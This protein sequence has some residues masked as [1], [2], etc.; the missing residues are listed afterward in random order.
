MSV[1][2]EVISTSL[3]PVCQS[4]EVVLRNEVLCKQGD[5]QG[6]YQLG[7]IVNGKQSWK[8]ATQAIWFYP[9]YE[10]WAIGSL[11]EIG[12]NLRGISSAAEENKDLF[13]VANDDWMYWDGDWK[14][15]N[16]GDIDIICKDNVQGV[17]VQSGPF[18]S[19]IVF[20]PL[21]VRGCYIHFIIQKG[22]E[23]DAQLLKL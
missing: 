4:V 1:K 20:I 17:Q 11:D 15:I 18:I 10:D 13:D 5:L 14:S 8:T 2:N 9:E 21:V 16:S 22:G 23:N 12:T 7:E 3:I 19:S 6:K